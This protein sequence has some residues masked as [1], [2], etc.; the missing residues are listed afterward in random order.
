MEA[1]TD[2]K[3]DVGSDIHGQNTGLGLFPLKTA[4]SAPKRHQNG[5]RGRARLYRKIGAL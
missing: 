4:T 2:G 1:K 5:C 3:L